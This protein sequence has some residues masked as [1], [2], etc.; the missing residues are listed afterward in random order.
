MLGHRGHPQSECPFGMDG[1]WTGQ[2]GHEGDR[3][4]LGSSIKS[5]QE[6]RHFYVWPESDAS[7]EDEFLL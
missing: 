3:I 4:V 5:G 7:F 6:E 2:S 1:C